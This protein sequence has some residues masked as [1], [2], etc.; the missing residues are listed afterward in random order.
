[1][2]VGKYVC[3]I[4]TQMQQNE[5]QLTV[6]SYGTRRRTKQFFQHVLKLGVVFHTESM[7]PEVC[8][9]LEVVALEVH[10]I[11]RMPSRGSMGLAQCTTHLTYN[12]EHYHIHAESID[13]RF[14]N[15]FRP[16]Y[17]FVK[18]LC[19]LRILTYRYSV[20]QYS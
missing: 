15:A 16:V 18:K 3:G 2:I 14:V 19:S 12:I 10:R 9:L 11:K 17:V 6:F 20:T 8:L 5:L 7:D 4:E 13:A 1:M